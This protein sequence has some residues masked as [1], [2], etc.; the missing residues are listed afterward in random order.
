M[1]KLKRHIKRW[2]SWRK[3]NGNGRLHHILVLLGLVHSPTFELFLL[4]DELPNY[5]NM[6]YGKE[7]Y[8][9]EAY[10]SAKGLC[11]SVFMVDER[12]NDYE[13]KKYIQS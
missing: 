9:Q 1:N 5:K 3:R 4:P 11:A 12:G 6:F 10:E 7:M 13:N 2:N 8:S